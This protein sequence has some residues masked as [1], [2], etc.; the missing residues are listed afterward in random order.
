MASA[1]NPKPSAHKVEAEDGL[2]FGCALD[3]EGGAGLVGWK[4][5][6]DGSTGDAPLWMHLDNVSERA[7][8]WLNEKSNIP[9]SVVSALLAKESRPRSLRVE[10]GLLVILRGVN[11]NE[12]AEPEDMVAIRMWVEPNRII[13]VRYEK[14]LTPRDVLG[15]LIDSGHGPHT[16]PDLFVSL[17]EKLSLKINDVIIQ[18]EDKLGALEEQVET[19][20]PTK[21]RSQLA[22]SRQD[23]V[24]LRRYLSPQREALAN[25]QYDA[26]DWLTATHKMGIRE[27]ADRTMRYLEDLD[28]ARDRAVVVLDELAN[29]MAESMNQTMYA[30]SIVAAIFLPVSFLTGLLGIN[31]GGM[32]GV[33]SGLAFWLVCGIMSVV[34]VLEILI[35]KRLKWI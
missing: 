6:E 19:E 30:L 1:V 23:T 12:G 5:I 3:G 17:S 7:I 15:D 35:L 26:P 22:E 28:A 34:I 8:T 25:L 18:L 2:L 4:E 16:A 29:K 13:T 27:T 33:D 32:P 21:L 9:A 11:L 24:A 20:Q 10:D 31:V 14:L